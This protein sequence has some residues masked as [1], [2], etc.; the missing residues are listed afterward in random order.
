MD[1]FT[2]SSESSCDEYGRPKKDMVNP[3][4]PEIAFSKFHKSLHKRKHNKKRSKRR[5][6]KRQKMR[7]ERAALQFNRIQKSNINNNL[8]TVN[9]MN[10]DDDMDP[11]LSPS[12]LPS[13]LQSP[14]KSMFHD[15]KRIDS[16]KTWKQ[17]FMDRIHIEK[18]WRQGK[19]KV[20]TLIGH[21]GS[22]TDL[23]FDEYRLITSSDDGSII[24]WHLNNMK[25][26]KPKSK[27]K[28]H[29][30]K[31]NE[32]YRKQLEKGSDSD[33][34]S[35]NNPTP[36][37]KFFP[38]KEE[39]KNDNDEDDDDE[40]ENKYDDDN[41]SNKSKTPSRP[42]SP[43]IR[44]PKPSKDQH[45]HKE[46]F[47]RAPAAN[48][49][50]S[51]PLIPTEDDNDSDSL[52]SSV[53]TSQSIVNIAARKAKQA[54]GGKNDTQGNLQLNNLYHLNDDW[55]INDTKLSAWRHSFVT[56]FGQ[57]FKNRLTMLKPAKKKATKTW[58][59]QLDTQSMMI[60]NHHY[61][62]DLNFKRLAFQG[63][64]GPIW[65]LDFDH[66]L[67]VSG[68]YDKCIKIWNIL[69]GN[70][71]ATLR[72]H[73]EWV[74]GIKIRHKHILSCSWDASI[75]L[76]KLDDTR[77]SGKCVS[78]L[79]S[80]S[81]NAI[82]CIQ[83]SVDKN[84]I[85]S[86][87]E[88]QAIQ[89]WDLQ[90]EKMIKT[91]MGHTKQVYCLQMSNN[92][93]LSGSA[94]RTIKMW[95]PRSAACLGSFNDHMGPVMKLQFDDHKLI[96]AGYDKQVRLFDLRARKQLHSLSGHSKGIFALQY[97]HKKIITGSADKRV[98][99]WNFE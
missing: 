2:Y 33:S 24:L 31:Y 59:K 7:A 85:V 92:L 35:N 51:P 17:Q 20:M 47:P 6:Y 70:C 87:C 97:D 45:Q 26:W 67:L 95:D 56:S 22:I 58:G 12:P 23:K 77:F 65:A 73:E 21:N 66:E 90:K 18:N 99:V 11:S 4:D 54:N 39:K 25:K 83:W 38:T 19:S 14:T 16:S 36:R 5:K 53:S 44:D 78:K 82:Y 46:F 37:Y 43:F 34:N 84:F 57:S 98:L 74:S 79:Q 72:G 80:Q 30:K 9:N 52:S 96:S 41:N 40:N 32:R 42:H 61:S 91:F 3:Y 86:G 94:D 28:H 13:P 27:N 29:N 60:Q 76:W 88:H 48:K 64:G 55:S 68:S 69:N 1:E 10:N 8:L 93:I 63:H 71:R 89:V 15:I 50:K 49:I 62:K 81:G 75:R